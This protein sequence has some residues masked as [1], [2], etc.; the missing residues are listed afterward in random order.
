[1]SIHL[2][3]CIRSPDTMANSV[4]DSFLAGFRADSLVGRTPSLPGYRGKK[5][6]DTESKS[7]DSVSGPI[8]AGRITDLAGRV[9]P[10]FSGFGIRPA[11]YWGLSVYRLR[12]N[13]NKFIATSCRCKCIDTNEIDTFFS[14][15]T[16]PKV[17][18]RHTA[19]C[20]FFD[21]TNHSLVTQG[22][23][24]PPSLTRKQIGAQRNSGR[25]FCIELYLSTYCVIKTPSRT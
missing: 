4:S 11:G 24:S 9:K 15:Q 23:K 22:G 16:P 17:S 20:I 8:V 19:E 13:A 7:S 25:T 3:P 18:T 10:A 21:H 12:I 1:M 5:W 6:P 2:D 14:I